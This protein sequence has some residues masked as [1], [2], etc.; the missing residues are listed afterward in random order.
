MKNFIPL[1]FLL[2]VSSPLF[3]EEIFFECSLG[4]VDSTGSYMKIS[5]DQDNNTGTIETDHNDAA[6]K[7]AREVGL[8]PKPTNLWKTVSITK[9]SDEVVFA[10]DISRAIGMDLPIQKWVVNRSSL[11]LFYGFYGSDKEGQCKIIEKKNKF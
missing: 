3:S 5:Y 6:I 4:E 1:S 9:T 10:I 7:K 8:Y 2:M 11:Q